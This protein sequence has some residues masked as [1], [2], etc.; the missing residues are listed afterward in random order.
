MIDVMADK[1]PSMVSWIS[2]LRPHS[3]GAVD[4]ADERVSL[5][6]VCLLSAFTDSSVPKPAIVNVSVP[7]LM[8]TE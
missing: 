4:T 3:R 7:V 2:T 6:W 8:L 1:P 5:A